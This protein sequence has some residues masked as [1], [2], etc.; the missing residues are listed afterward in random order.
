MGRLEPMYPQELDEGRRRLYEA[1]T[2][3]PRAAGRHFPLTGEHGELR[4]PFN[5]F[6]LSP[7]LGGVL[8]ELGAAVRYRSSLTPRAREIA[9]L[10]VAAHWDCAYERFAHERVGRSVGI[11]EAE[12]A[13]LRG[14]VVP[15]LDDAYE[16]ACAHLV[17][18][19]T[20][21][22]VDEGVW[23]T[24]VPVVGEATVFELTTLV[25]YYSTLALQ[26]RVFR[27]SP[28]DD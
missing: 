4:G 18:A 17:R 28:Y 10:L 8:Q 20:R 24:W 25:G 7:E 12:L 15:E 21:G 11:T 27:V 5:A 22:D 3:G 13:D 1:I 23:E 26:L 16:R 6:L 14:G 9:I 19:M 2:K